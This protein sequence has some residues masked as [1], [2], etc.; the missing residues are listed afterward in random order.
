MDTFHLYNINL[1]SNMNIE[2]QLSSLKF[3]SV[4]EGRGKDL[5]ELNKINNWDM[6]EYLN[7]STIRMSKSDIVD[8]SIPKLPNNLRVFDC[9]FMSE[10]QTVPKL[11]NKCKVLSCNSCRS[12]KELP[13][14]PQ[15]IKYIDCSY[16]I[17]IK[18]IKDFNINL[19][20]YKYY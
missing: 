11:P 12:L 7:I 8:V 14:L 19:L 3:K 6:I 5:Y 16:C 1:S 9:S 2:T 10:I 18:R 13:E 4:R 17:G 15:S 20:I